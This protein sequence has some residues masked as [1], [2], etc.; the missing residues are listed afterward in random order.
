MK[1]FM[2]K[3]LFFNSYF[4]NPFQD[5]ILCSFKISKLSLLKW[6]PYQYNVNC[7]KNACFIVVFTW[8]L[9]WTLWRN[10]Q[11]SIYIFK[12]TSWYPPSWPLPNLPVTH[13]DHKPCVAAQALIVTL[14][15]DPS[16]SAVPILVKQNSPSLISS[17]FR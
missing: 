16:M 1:N 14:L 12:S 7:E 9:C 8:I 10:Y 13:R 15:F 5:V 2:E 6:R 11:F 4:P 3:L 17:S